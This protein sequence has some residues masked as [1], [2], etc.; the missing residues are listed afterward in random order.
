[1]SVE[2]SAEWLRQMEAIGELRG[3]KHSRN[4]MES[5]GDEPYGHRHGKYEEVHRDSQSAEDDAESHG[6][7]KSSGRITDG[8][9]SQSNSSE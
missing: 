7:S 9:S 1:M 3:R 4:K 2:P 8:D 5:E 6:T